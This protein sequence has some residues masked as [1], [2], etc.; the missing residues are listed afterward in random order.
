METVTNPPARG[1]RA[2]RTRA[3]T[4]ALLAGAL[5]ALTACSAN[6]PDKD[7]SEISTYVA[8][9]DSYTSGVGLVPVTD[10]TCSRSSLNY[11][12]LIADRLEFDDFVDASCAGASST[13]LL[14]VQ[15]TEKGTNAPQL[16]QI[17][18][19]AD[20]VTIGLG[21]NDQGLSYYLLYLCLEV[22]GQVGTECDTYLQQPESVVDAAI[23]AMGGYVKADLD[24][25]RE[26]APDARIVLIGYPRL[27]PDKGTCPSEV[28]LP[29]AAAVRLRN[30][31]RKVNEVM[32]KAARSARV[33]Y[34]DTFTASEGHDACS[35][36]RWVN[37]QNIELGK[38]LAFH[39]FASYHAAVAAKLETLL[40]QR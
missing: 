16:E 12:S 26:R 6:N 5:V 9:G 8:L 22:N 10:E 15:K 11:S 21:L 4:A 23:S 3:S 33:D 20:L 31:L 19:D 36:D 32:E 29:A 17:P 2:P 35:S 25:I 38:A 1:T 34:V 39:P 28:P 7:A 14:S 13:N 40:D 27:L 18:V 24:A 37:G 30:S